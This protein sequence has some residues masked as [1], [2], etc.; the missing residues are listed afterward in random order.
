MEI[1]LRIEQPVPLARPGGAHRRRAASVFLGVLNVRLV[2]E[3]QMRRIE[4]MQTASSVAFCCGVVSLVAMALFGGALL[5]L[6]TGA[7]AR[8]RFETQTI[9]SRSLD[10]AFAHMGQRKQWNV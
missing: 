9:T 10:G 6:I 8:P 7:D 5:N 2:S 3:C 4:A 1:S